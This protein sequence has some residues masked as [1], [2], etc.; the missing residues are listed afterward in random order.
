MKSRV[1]NLLRIAA[2]VAAT[3]VLETCLSNWPDKVPEVGA[4]LGKGANGEV[5][6]IGGG[7]TAKFSSAY[8][9]AEDPVQGSGIVKIHD[10]V[11]FGEAN[12]RFYFMV[13]MD[14][15]EPLSPE[16]ADGARYLPSLVAEASGEDYTKY[17]GYDEETY[18]SHL[19]APEAW[20]Q[21]VQD[22]KN[23]GAL[24]QVDIV[25]GAAN[26]MKDPEGNL[27]AVDVL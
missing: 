2:R 18:P 6:D 3:S 5:Y 20:K 8:Q 17:Y 11:N 19:D 4:L 26:V 27:V 15:L 24:D 21:L 10:V 23:A 16:E 14:R 25:A 7:K 1:V 13:I 22:W 12:G 9:P